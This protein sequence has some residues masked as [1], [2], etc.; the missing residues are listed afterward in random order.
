M[1]LLKTLPDSPNRTE[2]EL[3][4]LVAIGVPLLMT[5]GYAAEEV[6]RTYA[7][8]RELCQQVCESPQLLPAVAGLFRFY[9]VRA[10][11]QTA[12]A[13]GEQVLGLAE[14]T[15]DPVISLVGHSLLGALSLSLGEFVAG[16]EHLEKGI[17]LYD[18]REHHFMAALYG[19]DPGVTCHCFAAMSLWLLGY[20]D[21]AL[22]NVQRALA[23]AKETGSPYCETFALDFVTWIHVLRREEPAAQGV[24]SA[25]TPIATEQGF[26][27]LLADSRVLLGWTLAA[28]GMATEG[29]QEVHPAIAAYQATGAAMSAPAH[30]ALLAKVYGK[31]GQS[32]EGLAALAR[33]LAAVDQTGERTYEAE[34]YRLRGELTLDG[35]PATGRRRQG[36]ADAAARAEACFQK[37]I[38]VARRQRSKSLELRAVMS[39]SRLWQQQGKRQHAHGMLGEIYGWFTEGF[40]TAD[41]RDARTLLAELA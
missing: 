21:Q 27:F 6:E 17:A 9:F 24:I 18:P 38:E 34:L 1:A 41:L 25:L 28:Q 8:A 33:A 26:Q 31:A 13:L 5:K 2:H 39:L 35:S 14:H 30:L 36:S 3:A 11:F 19:D 22:A 10:D 23:V 16:R 12:R 4:L 37:A 15:R 29:L 7:R 40:D 32:E 20:P